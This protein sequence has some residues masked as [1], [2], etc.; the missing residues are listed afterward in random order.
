MSAPV[1]R[2]ASGSA[3]PDYFRWEAAGLRWLRAAYADAPVAGVLDVS[4]GHLDLHR[5][6]P[7]PT[8][9]VAAEN[10][11]RALAQVHDAGAR[12]FG[13]APDGWSGDGWLGPLNELLPLQLGVTEDWGTFWAESRI[14]PVLRM[15]RD[16]GVF[17]RS[18]AQVFEKL[19]ARVASLRF[20][21][22]S[23]PARLHGDL[24]AGNLMWTADGV[25]M[26]DPAAHGGHRVTDL[27]MLALFNCPHLEHILQGYESA[28][29]LDAQWREQIVLHQV[30]PLMLHTV[31]FGGSYLDQA[32]AAARRYL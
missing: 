18:A 12:G 4:D 30:H 6:T 14:R 29:R 15:G 25:V 17:D 13:A 9:A 7:V 23:T 24:W 5:L 3:P 2:K 19:A 32:L 31:I 26:I 21:D 10:F 11:G 22:G 1:F 16:R 20:D 8:D 27:A 28:H